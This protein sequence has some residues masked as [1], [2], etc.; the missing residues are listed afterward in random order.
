M[1]N[2]GWSKIVNRGEPERRDKADAVCAD[3]C[4]SLSRLF[5]LVEQRHDAGLCSNFS[6]NS[7]LNLLALFS[8]MSCQSVSAGNWRAA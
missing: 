4:L 2:R 7:L 6:A 3:P 8:L 1:W 5:K